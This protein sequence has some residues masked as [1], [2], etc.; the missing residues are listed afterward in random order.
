MRY[1]KQMISPNLDKSPGRIKMH[2]DS[3]ENPFDA[4]IIDSPDLHFTKE[5]DEGNV[6]DTVEHFPEWQE[7]EDDSSLM[8]IEEDKFA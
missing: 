2:K 3:L 7:Q 5:D 4:K 6:F 8:L 1:T